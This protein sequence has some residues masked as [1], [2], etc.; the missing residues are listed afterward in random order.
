MGQ[1]RVEPADTEE[2]PTPRLPSLRDRAAEWRLHA[3]SHPRA[4]LASLAET[5]AETAEGSGLVISLSHDD[6]AT[7][8]GGGVQNVVGDEQRLLGQAGWSYLHLSPAVPLPML[9]DDQ[10]A[11]RFQVILRLDGEALGAASVADLIPL[12]TA[13]RQ[14]GPRVEGIV[15][16]LMGHVPERLLDLFEAFGLRHPI[17]WAHDYFTLCPGYALLRNDEAFCGGPPPTSAAC[18][19]CCYGPERMQHLSRIQVFFA[20]AKPVVLAPSTRALSFLKSKMPLDDVE[21]AAVPIARLLHSA[22]TAASPPSGAPIRVAHVGAR[23]RLKG[24]SVFEDLATTLAQDRR[25]AFFQLGSEH[26]AP[27][28]PAVRNVPVLVGPRN[29]HGMVQAIAEARIDVVISWSICHE[30]FCFTAHEALAAGAFV[31]THPGTGGLAGELKALAPQQC[32]IV[33]DEAALRRLLQGGELQERVASAQRRYGMLLPEGGSAPWL[34][35]HRAG[36]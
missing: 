19:T 28:P 1:S 26:G 32:M 24:W 10:P 20:K 22:E 3:Q 18:L 15:H 16:H 33:E 23:A 34:L 25:Y 17:V 27:L 8:L 7:V 4:D 9:A 6:Y 5:L 29:R 30:T 31:V 14:G 2:K 36:G 11:D 21:T 35:T 12:A 13:L